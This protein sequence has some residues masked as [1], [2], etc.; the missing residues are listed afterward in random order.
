L[1]FAIPSL[2]QTAPPFL[3]LLEGSA[4][5]A[6]D[7]ERT[8]L[9]HGITARLI[10]GAST[11]TVD[12]LFVGVARALDFPDYFGHNWPALDECLADLEW[13]GGLAYALIVSDASLLLSEAS[14]ET[15]AVF[16]RI[17]SNAA[18]E[19]ATPVEVGED[20]DRPARPFHVV[21]QAEAPEASVLLARLGAASVE[22]APLG[23]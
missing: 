23:V 16:L 4:A 6:A 3:H 8:A 7:L 21:F 11:S 19:W 10:S 12:A 22:A 15:F 14:D 5:F 2:L 13:L 18:H 17:V 1:D 9:E 20:W